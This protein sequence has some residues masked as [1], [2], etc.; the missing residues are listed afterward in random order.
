MTTTEAIQPQEAPLNNE[1]TNHAPLATPSTELPTPLSPSSPGKK[2]RFLDNLA[3]FASVGFAIGTISIFLSMFGL[4]NVAVLGWKLPV[5]VLAVMAASP[6]ALLVLIWLWRNKDQEREHR[7]A[8]A[9]LLQ[10]RLHLAIQC[11]ADGDLVIR[12]GGIFNLERLLNLKKKNSEVWSMDDHN[13]VLEILTGY[14]RAKVGH[15]VSAEISGQGKPLAD[16]VRAALTVLGRRRAVRSPEEAVL[17]FEDVSLQGVCL[18][19][20]C[21]DGGNFRNANLKG[22][23]LTMAQ[24]RNVVFCEAKLQQANL[25]GANLEEANLARAFLTKA[26]LKD[27]NL[28]KADL[29]GT[30]LSEANLRGA[31]LSGAILEG[32]ILYGADLMSANLKGANLKGADLSGANLREAGLDGADLAGAYYSDQTKFPAGFEPASHEIIRQS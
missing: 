27:S 8:E 9:R 19:K 31:N 25:E 10:E 6:A 18:E 12:L 11:L 22:A 3:F 30:S 1:S 15:S 13:S 4:S 24:L 17:D 5:P 7:N 21:L 29:R 32:A 28:K 16:D 14:I 23:S 2:R 26:I 20:A